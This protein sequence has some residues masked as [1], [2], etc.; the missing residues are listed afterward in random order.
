M[1]ASLDEALDAARDQFG[2]DLPLID[3]ALSDPYKS[4]MAKAQSA[5]YYGT[6]PAMGFDCHH[7]AFRQENIDWQVWIQ[8]GPQPLIR[9]FVITH[10]NEDGA[11]E[12]T[13]LIR[14]WDF[15]ERPADSNFAFEPPRGAMK[16]EMR[17]GK[18]LESQGTNQ[19]PG[20]ALVTPK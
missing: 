8:T 1:P 14:S 17:K 2:I 16:V 19:P 5:I 15:L 11:P 7:L 6:A 12:F 20:T 13:G 3:L 9:K 4:G 18:E 10:K